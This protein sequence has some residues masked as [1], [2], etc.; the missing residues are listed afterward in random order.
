M[1]YRLSLLPHR[2]VRLLVPV[3]LLAVSS[4]LVLLFLLVIIIW[5]F[6]PLI[7]E[8]QTQIPI[9]LLSGHLVQPRQRHLGNLMT[10]ISVQ[11]AGFRTDLSG[12]ALGVPAGCTEQPVFPGRLGIGSR[13][14]NQMS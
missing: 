4:V 8:I 14:L 11:F 13:S 9:F 5:L 1:A 2:Q 3:A 12:D 7:D 6:S 10:R